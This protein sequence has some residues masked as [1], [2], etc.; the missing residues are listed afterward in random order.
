MKTHYT[1][2]ENAPDPQQTIKNGLRILA[3]IIARQALKIQKEQNDNIDRA[4]LPASADD[5]DT[6]KDDI[7]C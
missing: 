2:N 5:V 4:T 6:A 1:L 7:I 3:R